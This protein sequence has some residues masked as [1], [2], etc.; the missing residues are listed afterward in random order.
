LSRLLT[1]IV[2]TSLM[3][4][5]QLALLPIPMAAAATPAEEAEQLIERGKRLR[6]AGDDERALPLFRKAYQLN[7]GPR[8]AAQLGL[9]EQA[10]FLSVD[11]DDHLTEALKAPET[12]PFL[13]KNRNTILDS[14]AVVKKRVARVEITGEPEGAEVL[15][16]GRMAGKVP[17]TQPVKVNA[18]SVDVELRSPGYKPVMRTLLISGGQYQ[19]VVIRLEKQTSAGGQPGAAPEADGITGQAATGRS[20]NWRKWTVVTAVGGAAIGVGVGAYGVLRH[21]SKVESFHALDCSEAGGKGIS[22]K[23]GM[24]ST[25]CKK[26]YGNIKDARNLAIIGFSAAGALAVTALILHL[27]RPDQR[28]SD[29]DYAQRA[30]PACVPDLVGRG[31][32]CALRF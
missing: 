26:A 4:P 18:G 16:N 14:L 19:P 10:L 32:T 29:A 2:L 15:V 20:S 31:V 17:L 30:A 12:D 21:D 11:A 8:T 23:T 28:S 22:N 3:A 25:P 13:K 6:E 7:P 1:A 27:T 9:V 24:E 5:L